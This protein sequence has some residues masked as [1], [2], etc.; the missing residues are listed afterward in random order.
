M[1]NNLN[2]VLVVAW[3]K[4][5]TS[6]HKAEGAKIKNDGFDGAVTMRLINVDK[7]KI[8]TPVETNF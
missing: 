8:Y 3:F 7:E 6:Q 1:I 2:K 5:E 4:S